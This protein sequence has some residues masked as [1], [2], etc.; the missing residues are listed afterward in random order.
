MSERKAEVPDHIL[1]AAREGDPAALRAL[2]EHYQERAYSFASRMCRS[3]EGAKD[4]LQD[5]LLSPVRA[6]RNFRGEGS[7]TT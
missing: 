3:G 6:L 7:F 1:G 4:V 2:I 5:T